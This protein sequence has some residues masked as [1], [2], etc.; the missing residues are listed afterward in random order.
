M[1]KSEINRQ[2]FPFI[3]DVRDYISFSTIIK[4]ESINHNETEIPFFSEIKLDIAQKNKSFNLF[5]H[6]LEG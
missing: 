1:K 6:I 2:K 4:K 5:S 3:L